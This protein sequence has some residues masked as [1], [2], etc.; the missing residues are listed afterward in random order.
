MP[1]SM[2]PAYPEIRFGG[3]IAFC[4]I[5]NRWH[6]AVLAVAQK[7]WRE[8]DVFPIVDRCNR[9]G[10]LRRDRRRAGFASVVYTHEGEPCYL[11]FSRTEERMGAA[12]FAFG[13]RSVA[14]PD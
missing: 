3:T 11:A 2:K 6:K 9:R 5:P 7:G 14:G 10:R 1:K 4:S 12:I 13:R 8:A